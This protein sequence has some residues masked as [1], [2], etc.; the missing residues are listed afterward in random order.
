MQVAPDGQ[1]AE[2]LPP[3]QSSV[4]GTSFAH[5]SRQKPAEQLSVH[6]F[7]ESQ[8][9]APYP[10]E[11]STAH[12]AAPPHEPS[13]EPAEQLHAPFVHGSGFSAVPSGL[14]SGNEEEH[15]VNAIAISQRMQRSYT[16]SGIIQ[17]L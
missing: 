5:S 8:S 9:T 14:G 13:H 1:R 7:V 15:A 11:Q 10:P 16:H 17:L 4:H 6:M 3:E 12:A 2:Q